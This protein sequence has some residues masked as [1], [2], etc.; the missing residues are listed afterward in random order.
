MR[1]D[2]CT[3]LR[4]Q[5]NDVEDGFWSQT[6]GHQPSHTEMCRRCG[7]CS[8][9]CYLSPSGSG[10]SLKPGPHI[11]QSD[12]L[13]S[14]SKLIPAIH[15]MR[16]MVLINTQSAARGLSDSSVSSSRLAR[17]RQGS[18]ASQAT[19]RVACLLTIPGRWFTHCCC[20][21]HGYLLP[22]KRTS[23]RDDTANAEV[24]FGR[25][26]AVGSFGPTTNARGV[27]P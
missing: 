1:C 24:F 16:V 2:S 3:R 4:H 23:P 12:S 10:R 15:A 6:H 11:D 19:T 20:K 14:L 26:Q 18:S 5:K 21:Q 27:L 17:A 13:S 22:S 9:R 25:T 7:P 8:R